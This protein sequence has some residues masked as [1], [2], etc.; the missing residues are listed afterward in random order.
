MH[1]AQEFPW[2]WKLGLL[3]RFLRTLPTPSGDPSSSGRREG[4][5]RGGIPA[6]TRH[7]RCNH[8]VPNGHLV[9]ETVPACKCLLGLSAP[10]KDHL[11]STRT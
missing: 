8:L 11:I 1:V 6:T 7:A 3:Y 10:T 5:G 9:S 4:K 2:N